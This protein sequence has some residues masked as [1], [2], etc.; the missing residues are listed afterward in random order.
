MCPIPD[1]VES[2]ARRPHHQGSPAG[3]I[4]GP[5][6]RRC[7]MAI[8]IGVRL[9]KR[10]LGVLLVTLSGLLPLLSAAQL[11]R[12]SP[13]GGIH[14]TLRNAFITEY[15]NRATI[16]TTYTVD[17]AHPHPNPASKDG[18]LHIAGRAP[19]AGLP[20]VAEIMNAK[21]H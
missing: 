8:G 14:I 4:V 3:A 6:Y 7:S 2:G 5:S 16:D 19:E 13:Q 20:I 18:D 15:K 1:R 21:F 17:K 10:L 11:N 12:P 9:G